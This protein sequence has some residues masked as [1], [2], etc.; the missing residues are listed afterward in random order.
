VTKE[1]ILK[2]N[3]K[4]YYELALEALKRKKYNSATT[5]FFK[6]ICSATDIFLLQNEGEIPSSHTKRFRI[7]EQKYP[8]IYEILDQ[9]FPF[10]QDSYTKRI[11]HEIVEVLKDDAKKIK[12]M[13]KD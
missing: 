13:C 6:A 4:E 12:E 7:V 9:D 2:E 3:F 5:L 11:S 8:L 1:D 10:Y